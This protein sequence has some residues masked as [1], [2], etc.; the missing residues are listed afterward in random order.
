MPTLIWVMSLKM[1]Q[2]LRDCATASIQPL[3]GLF[4]SMT[5]QQK[6]MGNTSLFLTNESPLIAASPRLAHNQYHYINFA[7]LK[8][9][10]KLIQA[11]DEIS[12]KPNIT[13]GEIIEVLDKDSVTILCL[14]VIFPFLQPIPIPGISSVL[15]FIVILQGIGLIKN[16]KPFLTKRLKALKIEEN[17]WKL[18]YKAGVRFSHYT[19]RLSPLKHR[20]T[21]SR[22]NQMGAGVSIILTAAFLSLPL[23]I[24]FSNFI[25]AV[26]ILFLCLG[27][28]EEDIFLLLLGHLIT[29]SLAVLIAFSYHLIAEQAM[30]WI[31]YF[32]Q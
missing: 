30:S 18:I 31:N 27:L 10:K 1:D 5:W 11:L 26:G 13:L 32:S 15:G 23:P 17:N 25:P 3:S 7:S 24:P 4:H 29:I 19:S 21:N 6:A 28:L 16:G 9:S 14:I 12:K 2:N 22:F 20:W 8:M